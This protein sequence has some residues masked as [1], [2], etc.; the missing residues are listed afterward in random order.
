MTLIIKHHDIHGPHNLCFNIIK[1]KINITISIKLFII[2]IQNL[3]IFYNIFVQSV[4]Y[5][6]KWKF[7][8]EDAKNIVW[9]TL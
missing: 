2:Y 8:L 5:Y 9:S 3:Y 7:D 6:I 1:L 4:T